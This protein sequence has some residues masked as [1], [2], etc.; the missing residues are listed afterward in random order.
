MLHRSMFWTRV[1]SLKQTPF[2]PLMSMS[3]YTGEDIGRKGE[4]SKVYLHSRAVSK[5]AFWNLGSFV[6]KELA[7]SF[8]V[9]SIIQIDAPP[10]YCFLSITDPK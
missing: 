4:L 1:N 10:S 9:P 5:R 6:L 2:S 7:R 8:P 3:K